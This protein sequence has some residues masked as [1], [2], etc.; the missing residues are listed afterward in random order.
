[1]KQLRVDIDNG[2]HTTFIERLPWGYTGKLVRAL[3]LMCMRLVAARDNNVV[4]DII[5]G[6]CEITY[7]EKT[8]DE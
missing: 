6:K 8:E 1:M 7:K 3:I 4:Y 5:A 2:M